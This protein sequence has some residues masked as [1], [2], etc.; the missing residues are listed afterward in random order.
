M[1]S[2]GN[3][4]KGF[5][6]IEIMIALVVFSGGIVMIYKSFLLCVDYL[7]YLNCRLYAS[8]MVENKISNIARSYR[9]SQDATFEFGAQTETLE[10]NHKWIDFNYTVKAD[11]VS[12][13]DYVYR[14]SVTLSWYDGRRL[15]KLSREGLLTKI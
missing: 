13:L 2:T 11:P 3:K 10:V 12:G 15:M 14:L 5:T 1:S 7:S 8:Q 4:N 6:F 9:E